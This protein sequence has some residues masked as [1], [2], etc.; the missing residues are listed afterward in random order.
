MN[1]KIKI[2]SFEFEINNTPLYALH[3]DTTEEYSIV[4]HFD[5][6][7]ENRLR[8]VFKPYQALRITAEDCFND[9]LYEGEYQRRLLE[10]VDSTW[11]AELRDTVAYY[12]GDSEITDN[13]HH[14]L[15]PL[16]DDIVEIIAWSFDLSRL[17]PES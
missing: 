1:G 12:E 17:D 14:F 6:V 3:I 8:M 13:A 11:L 5:D 15:L 7:D 10:I 9:N 2:A 4:V 16:G